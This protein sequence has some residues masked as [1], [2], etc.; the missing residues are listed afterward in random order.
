M[1]YQH[2]TDEP[3]GIFTD[4]YEDNKGLYVKRTIAMGTQKGREAYE[5][6]KMGALDGMSIGF[7]ADPDKQGYN[8]NK[9][10]VKN[11]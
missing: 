5:L 6:L 4:M 11:S 7:K 10:G 9:R 3:I 8:E 2:K 1:L